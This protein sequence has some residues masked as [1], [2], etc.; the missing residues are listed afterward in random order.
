CGYCTP[1]MILAARAFLQ[2]NPNPTEDEVRKA[3]SGN[4]CRCTGYVKIVE[5]VLDAAGQMNVTKG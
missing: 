3:L 2:K 5:A 1:G 4:L